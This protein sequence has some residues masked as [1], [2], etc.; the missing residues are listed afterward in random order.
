MLMFVAAMGLYSYCCCNI[1]NTSKGSYV[2]CLVSSYVMGSTHLSASGRFT[3]YETNMFG[4]VE[5][6]GDIY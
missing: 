4:Y 1:I 3:L 6:E 5:I 2:K